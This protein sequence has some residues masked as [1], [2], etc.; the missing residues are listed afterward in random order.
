MSE[1]ARADRREHLAVWLVAAAHGVSHF[2]MLL[3]IPLF[4][5]FKSQLGISYVQLGFVL[6]LSNI[7][8]VIAQTPTG[9]LVDRM[10]SRK[11]LVI[12]LV[13]GALAYASI[14]IYPSYWTLLAAA[15][16]AG[17][18]N[19]V[20]HPADYDILHHSVAP[21]RVG[22]AFS[23]HAFCGHI[24]YGLAPVVMLG[25]NALFGLQAAL[26]GGA[27]LGI[28]PAIPLAFA[29]SLDA[30]PVVATAPAA[31]GGALRALLTPTVI[32]LTI[33]FTLISLALSGMQNFSIPALAQLDSIPLAM[34]SAALTCF[35]IGNAVGV[36]GGGILADKTSRH[37]DIAFGGFLAQGI[38][39]FVVGAL[40]M[41]GYA[42][43]ALML[44]AGLFGG[45]LYPRATCSCAKRPHRAIG[46]TF[47]V[48]T[49]GFNLGISS[50]RRLRLVDG[51]GARAILS[52]QPPSSPHS[53]H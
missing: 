22:R 17:L 19:A 30:R 10:G 36:L 51:R 12:A 29:R 31:E 16:L 2:Y 49:T 41:S 4:P 1:A 25:L 26:I 15:V 21:S 33:F 38:I 52:S 24:G 8:S 14:G 7:V 50:G 47:A 5:L 18:V 6:V 44:V 20:Y 13:V 35:L 32:G 53:P 3:L 27:L 43:C 37:E 28:L 39:V 42:V 11:L 40:P 34:A 9:F 48:V 45:I 23:I 46:R